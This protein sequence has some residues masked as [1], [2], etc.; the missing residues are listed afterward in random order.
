MYREIFYFSFEEELYKFVRK[1]RT[2]L[3]RHHF[4]ALPSGFF[5][6]LKNYIQSYVVDKF[7]TIVDKNNKRLKPTED[8]QNKKISTPY[9][10]LSAKILQQSLR[11][12]GQPSRIWPKRFCF[13][14]GPPLPLWRRPN[15]Q[16]SSCIEPLLA[17]YK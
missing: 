5:F 1:V 17:E 13:C 12:I 15:S 6:F 2:N 9:V 16:L 3:G 11:S 10:E 14:W 8:K 4:P 7:S